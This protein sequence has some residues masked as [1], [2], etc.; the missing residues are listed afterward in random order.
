MRPLHALLEERAAQKR[1][2]AAA[3]AEAAVKVGDAA[4]MEE[5]SPPSPSLATTTRVSGSRCEA[6]TPESPVTTLRPLVELRKEFWDQR[7]GATPSTMRPMQNL[8]VD[9]RRRK[10]A[11]GGTPTTQPHARS[12]A[13][14]RP[15]TTTRSC[16]G[17]KA[18]ASRPRAAPTITAAAAAVYTRE[19]MLLHREA[20]LL[21]WPA[22]P[23][24]G[25]GLRTMALG[26]VAAGGRSGGGGGGGSP[27]G[28]D[29]ARSDRVAEGPVVHTPV[30]GPSKAQSEM[31]ST[32]LPT[33]AVSPGCSSSSDQDEPPWAS[34]LGQLR[35]TVGGR[36]VAC[37]HGVIG[38]EKG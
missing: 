12:V 28:L 13:T 16:G 29:V 15:A 38:M 30:L 10:A 7:S 11:A 6:R 5:P 35:L 20:L 32:A 27:P 33:P 2:R 8:V 3:A 36:G 37:P 23:P 17:S 4:V 21:A 19:I 9:F 25:A 14:Q 24:C 31:A 26:A 22:V 18:T 34:R 1:A